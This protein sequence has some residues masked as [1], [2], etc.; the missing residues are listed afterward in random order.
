MRDPAP[1]DPPLPMD[2][3]SES[4]DHRINHGDGTG[5]WKR[6]VASDAS[7]GR[8]RPGVVCG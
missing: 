1:Y 4:G 2:F 7:F 3:S 8:L 5:D 6:G